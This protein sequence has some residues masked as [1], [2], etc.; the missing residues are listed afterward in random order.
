MSLG[1]ISVN[2][3]QLYFPASQLYALENKLEM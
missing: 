2:C 1:F 3:G